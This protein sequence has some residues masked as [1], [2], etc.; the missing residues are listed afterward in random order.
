MNKKQ[1]IIAAVVII[2]LAVVYFFTASGRSVQKS[3]DS[4]ML[5]ADSAAVGS[6][7]IIN[8]ADTV[9][10][11]KLENRWTV[12]NYPVSNSDFTRMFETLTGLE[13]DRYVSKNELKYSQYGV[14]SSA[15]KVEIIDIDGDVMSEYY[16]GNSSSNGSETF[17][18]RVNGVKIYSVL[19]R[20]STYEKIDKTRY[21]KKEI[22]KFALEDL[23]AIS[24]SGEFAYT[25]EHKN[26]GWTFNDMVPD[27]QKIESLVNSLATQKA[28]V[29][30]D[31]TIPSLAI[32]IAEI[33]FTPK[34]SPPLTV[35][36]FENEEKSTTVFVTVSGNS[37]R[38]EMPKGTFNQLK[39]SFDDVKPEEKAPV[40]MP[41]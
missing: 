30:S 32:Q 12:D 18:R 13:I 24:A 19:E 27:A 5:I 22:V 25:L 36:Y 17:I 1:V 7:L 9:K 16:I 23:F 34:N 4:D 14:D 10:F 26:V 21:Y 8:A 39:K 31:E 40:V 6:L 2:V 33:Q 35:K 28:T 38:F 3:V 20:L 29:I 41:N 37:K 15:T 11:A